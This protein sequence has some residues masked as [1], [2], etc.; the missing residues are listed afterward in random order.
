MDRKKLVA[1]LRC[2]ASVHDKNE[3]L[4]CENCPY[5]FEE[6]IPEELKQMADREEGGKL[7]VKSCD[8]DQMAMDAADML[9]ADGERK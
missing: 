7:F 2:S 9:E 5:F 3:E 4:Q 6:E 1:A 8:M